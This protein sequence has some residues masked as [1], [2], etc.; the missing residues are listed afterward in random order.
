MYDA[1][2]KRDP[3]VPLV[4][5]STKVSSGL[6]GVESIDEIVVEGVVY[7][8]NK[9]SIVIANGSVLKEGEEFGNVKVVA[10]KPNGAVF[11]INGAQDFKPL[12]QQQEET[13]GK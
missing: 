7:D 1:H 8:A 10:I 9:G 3:F 12:Y 4:T 6:L 13:K 2:S 5:L 11:S